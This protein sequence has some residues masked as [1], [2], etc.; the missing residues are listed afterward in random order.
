MTEKEKMLAGQWYDAN[1]DKTLLNLLLEA[2]QICYDFNNARP[3]IG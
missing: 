3:S 1:Y 2:E